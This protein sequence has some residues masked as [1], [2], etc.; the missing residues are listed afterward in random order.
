[1]PLLSSL[2]HNLFASVMSVVTALVYAFLAW[3][4]PRLSEQQTRSVLASAWVLHLLVLASTLFERPV[5]F[6]FAP[7]LSVTA[8]LVLTVYVVESRM[9]PQ[10]RARRPLAALG[11]A[12]VLLAMLFPGSQYHALPSS[13]M[14]LHW[15]L[16]FASYGLIA[17]AVVH[18]WLMQRAEKAMRQ[19]TTDQTS[20]PLLTLERLT[21]R[22]V[23]AGFVLLS[24]T[25]VVGGW[26][27]ELINEHWVW[28]HK[29]V[30][31]VLA[32]LTMGV[33]L[34]G[35]W[36]L[37]WRGRI[38]VRMLYLGAGFLLLGYVGSRF[39]LEVVLHRMT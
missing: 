26:F 37:G 18:A 8:W 2:S 31:S 14:P 34:L 19:G 15:A 24:A 7:A 16:G 12:A 25:L 11:I 28:N 20:I 3:S 39:V 17:A 5:R 33:L 10:L 29:T 23:G 9:Y 6:G 13:W 38:A 32:W 30:F 4:H 1:M 36:R 22:F 35:R 21:F 27:S